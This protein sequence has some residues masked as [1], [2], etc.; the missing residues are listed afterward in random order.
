MAAG[1]NRQTLRLV[2][3]TVSLSTLVSLLALSCGTDGP[4][5]IASNPQSVSENDSSLQLTTRPVIMEPLFV[6]GEEGDRVR[7]EG[8]GF[9]NVTRVVFIDRTTR[10][11]RQANF[12]IVTD[13]VLLVTIPSDITAGIIQISS[14]FNAAYRGFR[15]L[16]DS[17]PTFPT[18]TPTVTPTATPTDPTRR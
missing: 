6:F 2:A 10:A 9:S 1:S 8:T 3:V 5:N 7:F 12:S 16:P 11:R 18:A 4:T 14:S 17:F 13:N 15:I